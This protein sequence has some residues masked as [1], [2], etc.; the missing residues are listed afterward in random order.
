MADAASSTYRDRFAAL[1]RRLAAA[2]AGQELDSLKSEIGAL[3]RLLEQ[4]IGELSAIRDDV[5]RLV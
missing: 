2:G 4:E 5:K 3:F 1:D